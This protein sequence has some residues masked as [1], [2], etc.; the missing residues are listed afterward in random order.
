MQRDSGVLHKC[1]GKQ[2]ATPVDRIRGVRQT[3][4]CIRSMPN[5]IQHA[6]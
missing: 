3:A 4:S 2:D 5:K 6:E 1:S